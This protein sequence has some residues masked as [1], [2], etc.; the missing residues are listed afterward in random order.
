[1]QTV[2]LGPRRPS[3]F[4]CSFPPSERRIFFND[5]GH[6][7]DSVSRFCEGADGSNWYRW[8]PVDVPHSDVAL[9]PNEDRGIQVR[10]PSIQ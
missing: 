7:S 8:I 1:M 3:M 9:A 6:L 2:A 10:N 5:A 4:F